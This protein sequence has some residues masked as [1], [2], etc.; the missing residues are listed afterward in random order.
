MSFALQELRSDLF[1]VIIAMIAVAFL[2]LIWVDNARVRKRRIADLPNHL[3]LFQQTQTADASRP[4]ATSHA[5][6]ATATATATPAHRP[7]PADDQLV[8]RQ[9][10]PPSLSPYRSFRVSPA[11]PSGVLV[12]VS[13]PEAEPEPEPE[14]RESELQL[15]KTL[16]NDAAKLHREKRDAAKKRKEEANK[17]KEDARKGRIEHGRQARE[18]KEA[19][20]DKVTKPMLA[21]SGNVLG[22][23][24]TPS[25]AKLSASTADT[26]AKAFADSWAKEV[27]GNGSGSGLSRT[28]SSSS[29]NSTYNF[30]KGAQ[31][32]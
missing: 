29:A 9:F 2:S 18:E 11:P 30:S 1:C 10:L 15:F 3:D 6:A 23:K 16:Q 4:A 7:A 21:F 25:E 17:A 14:P 8:R 13:E 20:P 32:K 24:E 19:A 22:K 27:M 28:E 31:P 26:A 5:A 12:A